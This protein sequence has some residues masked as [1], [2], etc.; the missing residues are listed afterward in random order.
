MRVTK[1]QDRQ[2]PNLVG[3]LFRAKTDEMRQKIVREIARLPPA[4]LVDRL[5]QAFADRPE[6]RPDFPQVLAALIEKGVEDARPAIGRLLGDSN[7]STRANAAQLI[8]RFRW[9]DDFVP[10]LARLTDDQNAASAFLASVRALETGSSEKAFEALMRL[11]KRGVKNDFRR[12]NVLAALARH[13]RP[14]LKPVFESVELNPREHPYVR[15]MA[16]YGLARLGDFQKAKRLRDALES[17]DEDLP[18][19]AARAIFNTFDLEPNFLP[20]GRKKLAKWWDEHIDE[21]RKKFESFSSTAPRSR[22]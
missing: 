21:V 3:Q 12:G 9:G 1:Q 5:E 16:E 2:I 14:E 22:A 19:E 7:P 20:A 10:E 17:G 18:V 15:L 8:A 13:S 11:W 4:G 6:A